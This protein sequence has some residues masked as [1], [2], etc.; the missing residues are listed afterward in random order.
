MRLA[1]FLLASI[2]ITPAFAEP[3]HVFPALPPEAVAA[4]GAALPAKAPR[5]PKQPRHI[6]V[7]YRT[8]AFVHGCIPYANEALVQMGKKTGAFTVE[9]SD[10]MAMFEPANLKRF[11]A[12]LFNNSTRLEFS[13]P[14]HRAA[15]FDRLKAGAGFIAIHA[16]ADNFN[17]WP[18]ARELLGAGYRGHPWVSSETVAVKL[19]EPSHPALA[20]FGGQ[21]FWVRD[22]IYQIVA[23]YDRTKQ[24]VLLSLD[25]SKPQNQRQPGQVVRT[26]N[27][28]PISWIKRT[29]EGTRV[30]YC[31]LGHN[32]DIYSTPQ[33]LAHYLAGI[34]YALG[35][36]EMDANPV[37]GGG[38]V[39]APAEPV[40]LNG[41]GKPPAPAPQ[42]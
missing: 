16:G 25:M 3:G 20:A 36:F 32:P 42:K 9:L 27:D 23:P 14:K 37:A 12:I 19:D 33:I 40:A 21:G 24:R 13:D 26:D 17:T 8:E 1:S 18:E 28:F 39:L 10:D 22:E 5:A 15:L 35:D 7:F 4:I 6:L 41:P 11:D 38:M 2:L 29:P 34:Q 31:S 30:F